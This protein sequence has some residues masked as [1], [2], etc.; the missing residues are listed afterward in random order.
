MLLENFLYLLQTLFWQRIPAYCT[1]QK[2]KKEA[3]P[4][5][6]K[7]GG[8]HAMSATLFI[9]QARIITAMQI[10]TVKFSLFLCYPR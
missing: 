5:N 8:R 9:K 1:A 6:E 3:A 4:D 7:K 2:R 10:T